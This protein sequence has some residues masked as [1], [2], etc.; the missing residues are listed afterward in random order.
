MGANP[1]QKKNPLE[2]G[3]N[4][5]KVIHHKSSVKELKEKFFFLL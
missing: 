3:E 4:L 5:A 2:T 1:N